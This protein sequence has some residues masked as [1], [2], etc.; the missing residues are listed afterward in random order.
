M[1]TKLPS[2]FCLLPSASALLAA[3]LFGSALAPG[4]RAQ[5]PSADDFNPGVYTATWYGDVFSLAVQADGKI[6]VGG[7]FHTLG[8]Q[9]RRRI[10]R[11]NA[12]GSLDTGFDP[13]AD[14]FVRS[15]AVQADGKI[16][17]GG[18]FTELGG[19]PRRYIGRLNADGTLDTGF[20]PV[21]GE[22]VTSLALQADGKI[23]VGGLF[24]VLG[25]QP[26]RYI[27]RLNADGSVDTGFGPGASTAVALLALQADGKI[28]VGGNFTYLCGQARNRI[29]R[30]NADGTLDAGFDPG[31]NGSPEQM[32]IQADGKIVVGGTFLTLAGETRQRIGRLNATEPATQSLTSDGSTIAW[33][34]GG[35]SPEVWRTTF[36][37]SP[38]G[39][40]WTDLGAGTRVPGGWRLTGLSLPPGGTIRARGHVI[41][42][43][44]I[45]GSAW[46]V[47]TTLAAPWDIRLSL[48]RD[49]SE[50]L[51]NWTGGQGPYQVQQTATLGDPG[52]WQNVGDPVQANSMRMPLGNGNQFLRVRGQ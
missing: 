17:V 49:G 30:L 37:H 1:K 2:T 34:R 38:D 45:N 51:L 40:T 21:A 28:L 35:T 5:T 39:S 50:A 42:S 36:E 31:A 10:G 16:L 26:H 46:F 43:G 33:L 9:P 52:S 22:G 8:G 20:D 7:D 14:W 12:D 27:G 3:I 13:G 48:E 11:L 41:T 47:E 44:K 32:A 6:L 19:Q 18:A 29:G 24:T 23:L 25:G 15:L 4:A